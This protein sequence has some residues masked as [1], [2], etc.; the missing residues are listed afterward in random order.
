MQGFDLTI[1]GARVDN[2]LYM[3]AHESV[4]LCI[5]I[6]KEEYSLRREEEEVVVDKGDMQCRKREKVMF[7]FYNIGMITLPLTSL[8]ASEFTCPNKPA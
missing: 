1:E 8:Y 6:C 2:I 4:Y 5:L 7:L 3:Y